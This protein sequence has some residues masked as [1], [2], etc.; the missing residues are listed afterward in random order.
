MKSRTHK[1]CKVGVWDT[2]F[3]GIHFNENGISNY[4]FLH[5]ELNE[6]FPRGDQGKTQWNKIVKTIKLKKNKNNYDCIV[7]VSGGT[8][9]SFL[10]H[11]CKENGL[12][13]LAVNLDNGWNSKIAVLNIKKITELLNFDL[14][15]YVIDY[16]EVKKIQRAYIRSCIPWVDKPTD[17]AIMAILYRTASREGVK[18]VLLGNDFRTEGKQPS[19]WTYGDGKQLLYIYN[20]YESNEKLR[21]FPYMTIKDYFIYGFIRNIKLIYPFNYLEYSK[22]KAQKLLSEKY[23]WEY[24]GGHHHENIFTRFI[25]GYWL[26]RK[27][28]IDKRKVTL[29]A[30]IL[31]DEISRD[32]ALKILKNPPYNEDEMEM[33]KEYVL[34]KLDFTKE[35]FIG[36]WNSPNRSIFDF[37]S[38]YSI[39][40]KFP[41]LINA[42]YKLINTTPPKIFFEMK[43]RETEKY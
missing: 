42:L 18:F 26:P 40:R 17:N 10:L 43:V 19:E 1:I 33:D 36:I 22:N 8:D 9:S 14:E 23:D 37:P 6:A 15:T 16:E 34:K 32:E 31:N 20:K 5:N 11:L 28:N 41:K 24:Y 29:S 3:P 35:D 25:I 30:Q 27:F 12:K 2:T 39:I 21:S 38:Y 4:R 7:G 13:A